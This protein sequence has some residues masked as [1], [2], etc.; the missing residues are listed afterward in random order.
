[1]FKQCHVKLLHV[2]NPPWSLP[3]LQA[4]HPFVS[5]YIC[6]PPAQCKIRV[7]YSTIKPGVI[8]CNVSVLHRLDTFVRLRIMG[9]K[10]KV[11]YKPLS[12]ER[13]V[14]IGSEILGETFLY[15]MAAACIVYEYWRSMKKGQRNED[16]QNLEISD[17]QK[18]T[19][20]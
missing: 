5:K 4:K 12:E 6:A 15:S 8:L 13:A 9:M 16:F 14:E 11:E 3:S 20:H 18:Q 10:G 7:E 17:L 1:M 19:Q 2:H